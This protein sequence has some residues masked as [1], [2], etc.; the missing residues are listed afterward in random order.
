MPFIGSVWTAPMIKRNINSW[1]VFFFLKQVLRLKK[2]RLLTVIYDSHFYVPLGFLS[3]L[4]IP[5]LVAIYLLRTRS[6]RYP[7]SSLML[8]V[9]Q[10]QARK[11]ACALIGCK[12][13]CYSFWNYSPLYYWPSQWQPQSFGQR[14]A[15]YR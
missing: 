13:P 11:A 1:G 12:H 15:Q 14:E 7:V 8:W 2:S 9:N 4:A 6:R 10:Q 5:G 3:L